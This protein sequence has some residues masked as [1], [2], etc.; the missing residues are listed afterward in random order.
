MFGKDLGNI[1]DQN[2][3]YTILIIGFPAQVES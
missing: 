1:M 2:D 3:N